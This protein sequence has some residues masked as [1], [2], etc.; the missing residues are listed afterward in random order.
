MNGDE[1]FV[2]PCDRHSIETVTLGKHVTKYKN[3][4]KWMVD[5]LR[6]FENR[7]IKI[8]RDNSILVTKIY[9][10]TVIYFNFV[11]CWV[12]VVMLA[13]LN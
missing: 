10:F 2:L 6:K 9:Q 7:A 4:R 12:S 8:G 13:S 5:F 11:R 1:V 3:I